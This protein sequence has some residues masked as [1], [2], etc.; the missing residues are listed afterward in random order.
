MGVSIVLFMCS[1]VHIILN[2]VIISIGIINVFVLTYNHKLSIIIKY[3][4]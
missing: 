4:H 3:Y 2:E 1:V